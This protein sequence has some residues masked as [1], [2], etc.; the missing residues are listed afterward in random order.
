MGYHIRT[1]LVEEHEST[2]G[3]IQKAIS[4]GKSLRF[5]CTAPEDMNRMKYSFNRI[6]K[7]TDILIRECGG[8]FTGLRA[9]VKVRE[10]WKRMAIVIEANVPHKRLTDIKPAQ[11]NERD[12]IESL[13]QFQGQMDLIRFTPSFSFDLDTWI[14]ELTKVGFEL[15]PDPDDPDAYVGGQREDGDYEY[16]VARIEEKI[17]SGFDMLTTFGQDGEKE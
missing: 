9:L 5:D 1:G 12:I 10:D 3:M 7:A 14:T 13:K 16:G 11:L 4:E 6:L 2:L 15:I 8:T 17:A